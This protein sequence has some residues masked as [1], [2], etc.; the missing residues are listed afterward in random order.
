MNESEPKVEVGLREIY[1][2]VIELK[3]IVA[4]HPS[5]LEDFEARIRDLEKLK[6]QVYSIATILPLAFTLVFKLLG[7]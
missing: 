4:S 5:K 7:V 6:Y 2:A 3:A 1:D